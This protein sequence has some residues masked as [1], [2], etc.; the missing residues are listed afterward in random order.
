MKRRLCT[1][2]FIVSITHMLFAGL[3]TTEAAPWNSLFP[4]Q[5]IEADPDKDYWLTEGEGPWL[6][7]AS[8][9]AGEKA[10]DQAR[11][12]VYELRSEYKLRAYLY[13][14]H[15]DYSA[16][17]TG[18]GFD[19]ESRTPKRMK[20][21]YDAKFDQYSVLIGDFESVEDPQLQ[22]ILKKVKFATP[23]SLDLTSGQPSS[24]RLAVLREIQRRIT[25]DRERKKM[26]PMAKAF[27]TRNPLLPDEYFVAGGLDPFVADMN[28]GVEFG[29]LECPGTYTV[30]VATFRGHSTMKLAEIEQ[31]KS[32]KQVSSKLEEAAIKAH[33]LTMALREQNVEAYE[34]H[35]RHESIV[36]IGSFESVGTPLPDGRTEL[37]P[38]ILKI[39]QTYGAQRMELP[40]QSFAG[41]APR[42]LQGI[43]FDVQ[44]LPVEVPRTSVA[45][46]YSFGR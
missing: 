9:F 2:T 36:T 1:L 33:E 38:A 26:G 46:N 20:H 31:L 35:D 25:P 6:I 39:M 13:K 4:F 40:G 7:L 14:R 16:P 21:E 29:L 34:F 41:L 27:A 45:A 12:L 43:T 42:Q 37:H 30:R 8:S 11:E 23:A 28:K 15:F 44:P 22:K 10:L 18:L 5:Q 3:G 32:A 19:P 17:V 24:Q